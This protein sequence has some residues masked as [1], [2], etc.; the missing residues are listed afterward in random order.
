[1]KCIAEV[2]ARSAA[3]LNRQPAT[4]KGL[5]LTLVQFAQETLPMRAKH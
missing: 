1:M 2:G 5:P 3:P 4:P